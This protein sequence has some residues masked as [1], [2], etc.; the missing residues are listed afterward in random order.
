MPALQLKTR[1]RWA[2]PVASIGL[3][4]AL[5]GTLATV[6]QHSAGSS[7][8]VWAVA[9]A[10]SMLIQ[11]GGLAAVWLLA[12]MGVGRLV[13]AAVT[14]RRTVQGP[15]APE[16]PQALGHRVWLQTGLGIAAMLWLCHQLGVLGLLS[17]RAG[18]WAAWGLAAAGLGLLADQ[19]VRGELR[20]E[21]WPVMP[22]WAVLAAPGV[23]VML[24][25]ACSPPGWL[26]G[27]EGYGFDVLEYHLELPKEWAR[28]AADGGAGR[29][30]PVEHNVYSYLPSYMEAAFLYVMA[31]AG[32]G[33]KALGG[34]G[35]GLIGCQMLHAGLGLVTAALTGRVVWG[36]A[37]STDQGIEGS[38]VPGS[39]GRAV[40]ASS[41]AAA[42]V[43]CLPWVVVVGS[44]AYNEL[45]V[46][47]LCAAGLLAAI[48]SGL[49]PVRRAV[50]AGFVVGV[51]CSAKPTTAFLGAPV[52]GLVLLGGIPRRHWAWAMAAGAAAGVVAIAPWLVR[53]WAAS[54]NPV[55]PF[56]S[57]LFGASHWTP[58][59]VARYTGAHRFD[60][61]LLDRLRLLVSA[62][63]GALHEQW[64]VAPTVAV[65]ALGGALAWRPTRRVAA[66]LGAGMLAAVAGW[67]SLTHL[68]SRFL[69]PLVV[70]MAVTVGMGAA[71]LL[72]WVS[73]RG[74]GRV[75]ERTAMVVCALAPLSLAVW[76]VGI[77][78]SERAGA[79]GPNGVL[80][81]G[82]GWWTG[83]VYEDALEA[84]APD[85]RLA[86]LEDRATPPSVVVN[87][88][89]A[90]LQVEGS[91]GSVYLLGESRALYFEANVVVHTPWDASP[92]GRAV[93]DH[94]DEPAAWTAAIKAAGVEFVLV[95]FD[96]LSRLSERDRWYDLVVTP[97]LVRRWL[98]EAASPVKEWPG[99][100]GEGTVLFRLRGRGLGEQGATH[101]GR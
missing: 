94:P 52:V 31:L 86:F 79:G 11:G 43:V 4:L 70:P 44:M 96:E 20:P 28:A 57:R 87:L 17:G 25:A 78:L 34:E 7:G 100:P 42:M 50:A 37:K 82:V 71:V 18:P 69:V 5:L 75:L 95:N 61:G 13:M 54:G 93:R 67:L 51:A 74:G 80:V 81:A 46:T 60:G 33:A 92:L 83:A 24:L 29:L 45:A 77:F 53:N 19:A 21:K 41:V 85:Q 9:S 15:V 1:G 40:F 89:V 101:G 90:P 91:A 26:W 10:V 99:A 30:W 8:R 22:A 64:A 88:V 6:G 16:A 12:A 32:G 68:Q 49:T 55:F 72:K 27:S 38:R 39:N 58:E 59:Q 35:T 48:E 65:V 63:R 23:A 36:V 84:R 14:W 76:S 3:T 62:D 2:G 56:A 98:T 66:L 73:S 97:D 47:A